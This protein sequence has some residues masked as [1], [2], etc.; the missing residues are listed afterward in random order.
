ML[1]AALLPTATSARESPGH[2][3]H[4]PDEREQVERYQANYKALKALIAEASKL[5]T[6]YL[7]GD[8]LA[9]FEKA[10]AA[11]EARAAR[12]LRRKLSP[13]YA[14][15]FARAKYLGPD[16]PE[17]RGPRAR[18]AYQRIEARKVLLRA[19]T[20]ELRKPD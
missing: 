2:E 14:H 4:E 3:S 10:G 6:D 9:A 17:S 12:F 20:T 5:Q 19:Y 1:V 15:E 13:L 7:E 11:W 16:V 8:D 18:A